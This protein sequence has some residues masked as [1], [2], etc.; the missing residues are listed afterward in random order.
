MLFPPVLCP[1]PNTRRDVPPAK[2]DGVILE[3]GAQDGLVLR[4]R[5]ETGGRKASLRRAL[6]DGILSEGE[7]SRRS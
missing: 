1:S 3:H 7:G 4:K 2:P 5:K 6:P